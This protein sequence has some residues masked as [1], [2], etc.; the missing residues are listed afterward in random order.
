MLGRDIAMIVDKETAKLAGTIL[1]E[2]T[3]DSQKLIIDIMRERKMFGNQFNAIH[4][5]LKKL[6][7]GFVEALKKSEKIINL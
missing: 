2:E 6:K 3:G 1:D 5:Q 4:L 7:Q